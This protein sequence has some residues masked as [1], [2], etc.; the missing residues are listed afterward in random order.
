MI[1]MTNDRNPLQALV[2]RWE[3]EASGYDNTARSGG[4]YT[5]IERRLL[6]MHARVKHGCAGDLKKALAQ[7]AGRNTMQVRG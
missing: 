6:E 2:E 1:A 7:N 3:R 5:S 4:E